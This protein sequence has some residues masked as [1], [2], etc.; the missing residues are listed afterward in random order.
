VSWRAPWSTWA[1]VRISP[2][3]DNTT[4]DPALSEP[5]SSTTLGSTMAATSVTGPVGWSSTGGAGWVSVSTAGRCVG[6]AW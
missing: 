1:L 2:L 5:D 6:V 4:H 3:V